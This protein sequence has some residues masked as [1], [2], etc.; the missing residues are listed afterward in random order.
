MRLVGGCG[1]FLL[2]GCDWSANAVCWQGCVHRDRGRRTSA[3]LPRLL[4]S[5]PSRG[6]RTRPLPVAKSQS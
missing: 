6:R 1:I 3:Y 2:R 5:P 4:T